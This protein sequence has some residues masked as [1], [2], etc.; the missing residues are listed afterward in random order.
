MVVEKCVE[1]EPEKRY[2]TA[3]ELVAALEEL[4][5]EFS[6]AG[7]KHEL[8]VL[9]VED[10]EEDMYITIQTLKRLNPSIKS[11][12]VQSLTESI[13][14][15]KLRD[16]IDLVLLDLNLPDSSGTQ[17]VEKFRAAIPKTPVVVLTGM[18]ETDIGDQCIR[19]GADAYVSKTRLG[20]DEL[21]R[22]LFV[23][24]SRNRNQSANTK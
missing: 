24:Y 14:V 6:V 8:N 2:Q 11:I 17:T 7:H 15:C 23:T 22:L 20:N 21:E 12:E 13:N 4:A 1:H 9:I 10:T 16:D 5:E 3:T 18:D 19:A